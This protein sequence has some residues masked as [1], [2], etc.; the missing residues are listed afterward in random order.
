MTETLATADIDTKFNDLIYYLQGSCNSLTEDDRGFLQDNNL[1]ERFD[2]DIF[3]C[4]TCGWWCG[5]DERSEDQDDVC[6]ECALD[7]TD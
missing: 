2:S 1:L 7:D 3:E 5:D 6:S 4:E